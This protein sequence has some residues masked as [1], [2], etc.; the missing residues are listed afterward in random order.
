[1]APNSVAQPQQ[2][3][4]I[5]LDKYASSINR[6]FWIVLALCA[7][8]VV[9]GFG[10]DEAERYREAADEL[11][12]LDRHSIFVNGVYKRVGE[13]TRSDFGVPL[14]E[15]TATVAASE[16]V[17]VAPNLIDSTRYFFIEKGP[18]Q[19]KLSESPMQ[20]LETV[21]EVVRAGAYTLNVPAEGNELG[22]GIRAAMRKD[23]PPNRTIVGLEFSCNYA[24]EQCRG[25]LAF[26]GEVAGESISRTEFYVPSR[27]VE[28]SIYPFQVLGFAD[29]DAAR[30]R[31]KVTQ[32]RELQ[33]ELA[34]KTRDQAYN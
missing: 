21:E 25:E 32:L 7:A 28:T 3:A 23:N 11:R 14:V 2:G 9:V 27:K 24:H 4:A 5:A 33:D 26:K 17:A 15:L 20:V 29:A 30:R 31:L 13:L 6:A 12:S 8:A 34:G 16:G 1:M 10:R 22:D 18:L 19:L